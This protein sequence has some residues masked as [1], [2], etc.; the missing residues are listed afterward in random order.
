MTII[1]TPQVTRVSDVFARAAAAAKRA[2]RAAD[3][4]WTNAEADCIE[5]F[6]SEQIT[7]YVY[8]EDDGTLT[9]VTIE[10]I[11]ESR[12]SVDEETALS[13]LNAEQIAAITKTV[14]D[15]DALRSAVAVGLIPERLAAQFTN[16]KAVKSTARVTFGAKK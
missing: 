12:M 1:E 4:G 13:L 16:Y 5:A 11:N 9:R 14:I 8:A 6:I 15:V 3:T 10:G 7:T 2:K